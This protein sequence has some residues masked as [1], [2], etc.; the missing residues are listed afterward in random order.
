[1]AAT[2]PLYRA[3]IGAGALLCA[4]SAL[5]DVIDGEWCSAA[6]TRAFTISGPKIVTGAG[7]EATGNY[8]RHTFS[9]TVPEGGPDA[10]MPVDMRL[11]NDEQVRV[12]EGVSDPEIWHRCEPIA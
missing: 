1:M 8:S 5:A 4:T 11:L 3:L 9:Y 10:G 7:V 6:G 12:T 2:A